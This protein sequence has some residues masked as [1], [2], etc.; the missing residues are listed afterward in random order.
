MSNEKNQACSRVVS[1]LQHIERK[2]PA[3]RLENATLY[4]MA[5]LCQSIL[6]NRFLEDETSKDR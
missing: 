2:T 4:T 3:E 5:N 1:M 6:T